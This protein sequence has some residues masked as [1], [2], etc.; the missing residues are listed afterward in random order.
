MFNL[1]SCFLK[2]ILFNKTFV[3]YNLRFLVSVAPKWHIRNTLIQS[4]ITLSK[5]I[6]EQ[7]KMSQ[8]S[9]VVFDE[10]FVKKFVFQQTNTDNTEDKQVQ[11]FF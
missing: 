7:Q 10:R 11:R 9:V 4:Q 5:V 8:R 1:C 3:K 6:L 2:S